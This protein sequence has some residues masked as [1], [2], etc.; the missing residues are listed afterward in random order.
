M[1]DDPA[2][3]ND[4][5]QESQGTS[6]PKAFTAEE[7]NR[8][9]SARAKADAARIEKLLAER[10]AALLAKFEEIA[11]AK[12]EPETN[13]PAQKSATESVEYQTLKK[14]LEQFE[15]Q[16]AEAQATANA[17]RSKARDAALRAKVA[18]ALG[19]AG[20]SG[21]HARAAMAMLVD[22]EK[23]VQWSDDGETL[24]FRDSDGTD[25]DFRAGL[26]SWLKSD[27]AKMFLPPRGT[28]GSG[29]RPGGSAPKKTQGQDPREVVLGLLGKQFFNR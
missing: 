27:D 20:V 25:I 4:S 16:Y 9:Y 11:T 26:S 22:S 28:A 24:A 10:E 5:P 7:F 19:A 21:V 18:D 14:K 3:G 23:R 8:A 1:A 17:E 15:R 13:A 6:A 29:D 2:Q 12:R